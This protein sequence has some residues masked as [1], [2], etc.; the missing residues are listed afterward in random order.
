[1]K[2]RVRSAGMSPSGRSSIVAPTTKSS[3]AAV[4]TTALF[5]PAVL[6]QQR[7]TSATLHAWAMQPRGVNG[8]SASKISLIE[9]M[10]ASPRWATKPSRKRRAPARSSG[11]H[12]QPGVDERADQP[13]PDRPLVIGGVARAQVAVVLRL[14][15]GCPGASERRPTGVSSRSRTT[16]QHRLPAR[17]GRAPGGRSEIAKTWFGRQAESSPPLAVDDVVQVAALGVPEAL[18]ERRRAPARRA[19][20]SAL[21]RRVALPRAQPALRAGAA[22]CTRAR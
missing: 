6:T 10:H 18:V 8:A 5:Y 1:M 4:W 11:M 21:G 19:P 7:S 20:P 16:S 2:T 9:P 14:V 22:R 3:S 12:L 17:R 13:G 15:V